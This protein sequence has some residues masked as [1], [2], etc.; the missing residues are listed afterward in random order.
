MLLSLVIVK[1][2]VRYAIQNY[3]HFYMKHIHKNV[4]RFNKRDKTNKLQ[5]S[6][7]NHLNQYMKSEYRK[8]ISKDTQII[9]LK[10]NKNSF[11][12]QKLEIFLKE[13][14]IELKKYLFKKIIQ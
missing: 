12:C 5:A 9:I 11:N 13:T 8:K 2:N 10:K 4:I 14:I 1:K 6:N 7:H 3:H